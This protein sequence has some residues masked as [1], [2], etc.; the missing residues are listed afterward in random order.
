M[1]Q[2]VDPEDERIRDYRD[3]KDVNLRKALEPA[4]GLF[5]AE[6]ALVIQQALTA[7]YQ[8][9]SLLL[10]A[11]RV[12]EFGEFLALV[13]PG[14]PVYVA[15]YDVLESVAGFPV[16][17]GALASMHRPDPRDWSELISDAKRL[18]I[19]EDIVDHTNL[20]A[21]FRSVAALGWDA[22]LISPRCADPL[23]RRS[24]RVSMGAVFHVPWARIEPWPSALADVAARGLRR[25]ALTPDVSAVSLER[26]DRDG[27]LALM[28]GSEGPGLTQRGFGEADELVRI[29]MARSIDSLNVSAAA[30]IALWALRPA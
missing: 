20:G 10:A 1:I 26:V 13:P 24:V 16:H 8:P 9:R 21:I 30:A 23:Y 18:V 29:P 3:L 4:G 12:E 15:E 6:S 14:T 5:I 17:R 19:L 7:G 27:A 28:L 2:L 11:D 25:V 22:V